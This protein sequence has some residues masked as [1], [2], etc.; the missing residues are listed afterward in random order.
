MRDVNMIMNNKMK[1]A[2]VL[3]TINSSRNG[4]PMEAKRRW[5]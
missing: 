2:L 1:H 5:A 3:D 4:R